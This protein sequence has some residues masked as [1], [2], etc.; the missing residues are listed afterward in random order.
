MFV[1]PGSVGQPRNCNPNA[2]YAVVDF[3]T[4]SV[5]FESVAYDVKLEQSLFTEVLH[6][7]YRDRLE[8]GI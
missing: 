8:K 7:Y 4:A 3:E 5:S 1:N 2:Q 6:P